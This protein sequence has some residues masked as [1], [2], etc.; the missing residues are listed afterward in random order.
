MADM[1]GTTMAT[2]LPEVWSTLPTITYR[3]T[4]IIW[5]L[6]DHRWEPEIGVGQGDTVN[7]GN[8]TQ[9]TRSNV[10]AR[11]TFGTGASV[12]F[13]ATTE[14][15]TQIVVN[16]MAIDA[17]RMPVEMSVQTMPM[18]KTL[19]LEGIG[20]SLAQYMDYDVAS[21]DTNGFDAFTAIGTDNVDVSE[22]TI[23]QGETNLND[24]L[25][26]QPGRFFM[27][28][29]ATRASIIQIDVLRN[30]LYSSSVGNLDGEKGN[31]YI[32]KIYSLDC[33]MNADLEAGTSGK[34]NFIGHMEAIAVAA[35]ASPKVV[36]QM[37]ITDGI[38]EEVAGYCIYGFKLV[39][40]TFG[41][42]V[43]GK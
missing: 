28:S 42:E 36:R 27:M 7:V 37:N 9:N 34:K 23:L 22:A 3:Q 13:T 20:Q 17:H 24:Y 10:N 19:L 26:P 8:F 16:K 2:F 25:A 39:K 41:R 33:Y 43:D 14:S 30:Q 38:F 29:P 32:G 12:T 21:D 1:T 40:S 18:Y 5:P 31:G 15:Q 4:Q 35:Q 6:L 11:S